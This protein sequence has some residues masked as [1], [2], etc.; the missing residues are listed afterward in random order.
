M[1]AFGV[2]DMDFVQDVIRSAQSND[3]ETVCVTYRRN[4]RAVSVSW[5][6]SAIDRTKF[7]ISSN[8]REEHAVAV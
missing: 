4:G 1:S 8:V 3:I 5:P 2:M 6:T 7:E